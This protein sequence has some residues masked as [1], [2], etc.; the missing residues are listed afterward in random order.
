MRKHLRRTAAVGAASLAL[1]AGAVFAS[2]P[3]QAATVRP[4]SQPSW[5]G[6]HPANDSLQFGYIT[7]SSVNIRSGQSTLCD[8]VAG[9]GFLEPINVRCY[10]VN[11]AGETWYYID[12][13]Y[14]LSTGWVI[15]GSVSATT[16]TAC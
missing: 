11:G 4:A 6:W 1:A 10:T 2:A 16:N 8:V 14:N 12:D 7:Y 5:C 15:A 9:G 13:L 3:A